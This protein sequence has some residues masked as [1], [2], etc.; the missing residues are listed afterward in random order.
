VATK[1]IG[2]PLDG[3]GNSLGVAVVVLVALAECFHIVGRHESGVVANGIE[4]TAQVMGADT[5]LHADE[6]GREVGKP[7]IELVARELLA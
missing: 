4:A 7:G 3:L 5:G 6:A 1:R 2:R